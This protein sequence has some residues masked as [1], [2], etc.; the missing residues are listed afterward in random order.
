MDVITRSVGF[1]IPGLGVLLV[2]IIFYLV[3]LFASN[4]IGHRFFNVIEDI[5]NRIP[6][7]RTTYQIGKQVSSSFSLP[8]KQVFKQTVLVDMNN[9]GVWAVGFVT[10]T[11]TKQG[12]KEKFLK[13]FIP[14]VPNPVSGFVI[15]IKESQ[16]FDPH[17]SVEEG[18]KVIVSG[19]IIGP[20][21]LK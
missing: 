17:W 20:E 6:I 14:N 10:G 7:L 15:V 12:V 5:F 4:V 19:G 21:Q 18:M 13:V 8:E 2:L 3:G 9:N 1:R 11:L 16:V